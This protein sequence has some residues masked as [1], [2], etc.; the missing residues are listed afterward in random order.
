MNNRNRIWIV[1]NRDCKTDKFSNKNSMTDRLIKIVGDIEEPLIINKNTDLQ[2]IDFSSVELV[3][4]SGSNSRINE[5][6]FRKEP[7]YVIL[8]LIVDYLLRHTRR[9]I[10]ILGICYGMHILTKYF[11]GTVLTGT[12]NIR[13]VSH[14]HGGE[15]FAGKKYLNYHD[16]IPYAP[17]PCEELFVTRPFATFHV[18]EMTW[19]RLGWVGV[20]YHPEGTEEGVDW[21]TG[22]VKSSLSVATSR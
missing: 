15:L 9:N 12:E 22:F 7:G 16:F 19:K 4:L 8:P 6:N 3:I 18:L 20:Q 2:N 10:Q 21:L 11:N 14:E 17:P 13:E 1:D 5:V